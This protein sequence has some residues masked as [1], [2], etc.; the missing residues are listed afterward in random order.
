MLIAIWD[1]IDV[2]GSETGTWDQIHAF[3]IY[4][5]GCSIKDESIGYT[6]VIVSS[7]V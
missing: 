6:T 4:T 7:A 5:G 1:M 3:G 2:K